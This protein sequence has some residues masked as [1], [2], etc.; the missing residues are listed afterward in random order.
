M[1]QGNPIRRRLFRSLGIVSAIALTGAVAKDANSL[2]CGP[3]LP[4]QA[5]LL[6]NNK[7][8]GSITFRVSSQA[9]ILPNNTTSS[10]PCTNNCIIEA[11][12]GA[13]YGRASAHITFTK[14]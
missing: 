3:G 9:A 10:Q 6:T 2:G 13:H 4:S 5:L 11:A 8:V 7:G 14:R 1:R 12:L